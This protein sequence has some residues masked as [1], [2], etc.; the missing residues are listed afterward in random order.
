MCKSVLPNRYAIDTLSL[1]PSS[2][3]GGLQF[4]ST[5][6]CL[7]VQPLNGSPSDFLLETLRQQQQYLQV[8]KGM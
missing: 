4:S 2:C 7:K 3:L 6:K 8:R 5:I 1:L